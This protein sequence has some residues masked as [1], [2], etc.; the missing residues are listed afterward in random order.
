MRNCSNQTGQ[1][2][3]QLSVAGATPRQGCLGCVGR[4]AAE[5]ARRSRPTNR[6]SLWPLLQCLQC[7]T[8]GLDDGPL[9]SPQVDLSVVSEQAPTSTPTS[10]A[11][12][13]GQVSL[14]QS[15]Q[16]D[17]LLQ[18]T[19]DPGW[20]CVSCHKTGSWTDLSYLLTLFVAKHC[21]GQDWEQ[22]PS[23]KHFPSSEETEISKDPE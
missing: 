13:R 15:F 23:S 20:L 9:S 5:Q 14:L 7:F 16:E 21:L 6:V 3:V 19:S 10:Q 4:L 12:S 1:S 11:P 18:H 8:S 22:L 17:V 2:P